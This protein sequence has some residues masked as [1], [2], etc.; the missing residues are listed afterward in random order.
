[1]DMEIARLTNISWI[2]VP[3]LHIAAMRAVWLRP[4]ACSP[5]ASTEDPPPVP[6]LDWP[7][8]LFQDETLCH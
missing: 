3:D 1:M 6:V 2:R 5:R 4:W 8:T 7:P